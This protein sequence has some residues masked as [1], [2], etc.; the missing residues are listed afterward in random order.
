VVESQRMSIA[1]DFELLLRDLKS[2]SQAWTVLMM[3]LSRL[4]YAAQVFNHEAKKRGVEVVYC[5]VPEVDPITR[6]RL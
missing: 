2:S 1:Q 3:R 5:K 6:V 4:R